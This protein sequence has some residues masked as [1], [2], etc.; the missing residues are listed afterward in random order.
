MCSGRAAFEFVVQLVRVSEDRAVPGIFVHAQTH[1]AHR[2][3]GDSTAAA[4]SGIT[5]RIRER[6][7]C[8]DLGEREHIVV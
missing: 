7:P 8:A 2:K 1:V 5:V 4:I 3:G 6:P